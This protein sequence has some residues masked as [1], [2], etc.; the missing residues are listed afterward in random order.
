[1]AQTHPRFQARVIWLLPFL[2]LAHFGWGR[3]ARR[4]TAA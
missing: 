3:F 4:E 2:A 1:M